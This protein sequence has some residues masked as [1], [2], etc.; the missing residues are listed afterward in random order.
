MKLRAGSILLP[1]LLALTA[2]IGCDSDRDGRSQDQL[3]Q[4]LAPANSHLLLDS[5]P[6][7]AAAA[8][9]QDAWWESRHDGR[10]GLLNPPHERSFGVSGSYIYDRQSVHSG[11]VTDNY[12]RIDRGFQFR[13]PNP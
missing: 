10:L 8:S 13:S 1:L 6:L 4:Y 5:P 9:G 2:M 11:R 12:H 3:F 7:Q